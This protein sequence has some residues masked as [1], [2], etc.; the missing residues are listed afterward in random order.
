MMVVVRCKRLKWFV[1]ID[2]VVVLCCCVVVVLMLLLCDGV[3]M[4]ILVLKSGCLPD[5]YIFH[6]H[7]NI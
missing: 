2:G 1:V 4:I 7:M 6:W 5:L 3:S